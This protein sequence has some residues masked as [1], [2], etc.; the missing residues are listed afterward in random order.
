MKTSLLKKAGKHG[1]LY[2]FRFVYTDIDDSCCPDF[3]CSLWAYDREHAED[4]FF[5][6]PDADG[7]RIVSCARVRSA[8]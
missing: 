4:R 7:W 8:A 5:D 1:T 3:D 2:L 6:G